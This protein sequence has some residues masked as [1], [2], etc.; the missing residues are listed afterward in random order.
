MRPVNDTL[1]VYISI[2]FCASKCT[3]CNFASDVFARD[4]MGAYVDRIVEEIHAARARSV[5]LNASLPEQVGSIYFGGGTPSLLPP[6]LFRQIAAALKQDFT[7]AP[8]LE[9]TIECAPGQ[10]SDETLYSMLSAGVNRFSFGVQSFVD[11]ETASV[12]RLHDRRQAEDA[13]RQ[14]RQ[15]GINN[16][17]IDLLAGLPH[18]TYASWNESLRSAIALDVPHVSVYMLE[19]DEDSRLG[20]ELIVLG[21]KYSARNVPNDDAIA[22]FYETACETLNAA[23]IAQYEISNF[24]RAGYESQHN[25]RYWQR[26]PYLG[27]G[28]DAHSCL[29]TPDGHALRFANSD[30]MDDYL[31]R[32]GSAVDLVDAEKRLEEAWFLGLRRNAGVDASEIRREFGFAAHPKEDAAA[33]LLAEGFLSRSG[34]VYKLTGRGRMLSNEVFERFVTSG[35]LICA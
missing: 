14:V 18:Q 12:G 22:D 23:G 33:V 5:Q 16:L 6:D 24:S 19:I 15:A 35:E 26:R 17:N 2:P 1:G 32:E 4:R 13:V 21:D 30:D 8:A 31:Q 25:L 11:R 7:L 27:F 29:P 9:W 28:L 34:T 3:F 20:S 10:L